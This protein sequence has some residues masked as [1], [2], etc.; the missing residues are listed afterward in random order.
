MAISVSRVVSA[1]ASI[2]QL[3]RS[4]ARKKYVK[5]FETWLPL[6]RRKQ[7]PTGE[8]QQNE[9]RESGSA[10]EPRASLSYS[11]T[12][13]SVQQQLILRRP[14]NPPV[15][16]P[17]SNR[18]DAVES[19]QDSGASSLPRKMSLEHLL[20]TAVD[21]DTAAK[22]QIEKLLSLK[23]LADEVKELAESALFAVEDNANILSMIRS[24]FIQSQPKN[25][26]QEH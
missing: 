3:R 2:V 4:L 22:G 23:K 11:S 15:A 6:R 7:F 21:L 20:K 18:S 19:V 16:T 13:E 12:G 24:Q 25:N 26:C 8:D 17:S 14:D 9:E 1:R 5:K 10:D